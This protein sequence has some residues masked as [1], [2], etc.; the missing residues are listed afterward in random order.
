MNQPTDE[1]QPGHSALDV[2][3]RPMPLKSETLRYILVSALDFF[4]TYL[5]LY[6]S[7]AD[8]LT[9]RVVESNFVADFFFDHWGF[10]GM[11]YFKFALVALVVVL[12]QIIARRRP[13]T[14]QLLLNGATVVVV[15]VVVYSVAIYLRVV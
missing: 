10:K 11:V 7:A 6:L 9:G 12:A 5:L 15:G 1:Q 2:F 8:L 14:A 4:V 13:K 3:R